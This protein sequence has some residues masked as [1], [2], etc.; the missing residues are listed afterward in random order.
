MIEIN[1]KEGY[2]GF[3]KFQR[4]IKNEKYELK[5]EIEA[6]VF[7]QGS[8]RLGM[9]ARNK[10]DAIELAVIACINEIERLDIDDEK[11]CY[12]EARNAYELRNEF[13]IAEDYITNGEG[14]LIGYNIIAKTIGEVNVAGAAHYLEF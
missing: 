5:Q 6:I 1:E 8:E 13:E 4:E 9:K 7:S 10:Q 2:D 12:M 11:Y 14:E 3:L